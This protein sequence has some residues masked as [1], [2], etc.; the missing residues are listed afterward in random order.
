MSVAPK[1]AHLAQGVGTP[2]AT[3]P[4]GNVRHTYDNSALFYNE[5]S[6]GDSVLSPYLPGLIYHY[7]H[8]VR[9]KKPPFAAT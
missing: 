4:T 8:S 6:I 3:A 1:S 9:G 5:C 7:I 2:A